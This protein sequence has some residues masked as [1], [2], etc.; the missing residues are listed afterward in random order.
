MVTRVYFR[1]WLQLQSVTH[2]PVSVLCNCSLNAPK[3]SV[4]MKRLINT[5]A[6]C[7]ALCV[8]LQKCRI[9][10]PRLLAV[11]GRCEKKISIYSAFALIVLQL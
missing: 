4:S 8:L 6:E 7:S 2:T 10:P 3:G 5:I 11:C 1:F 9:G